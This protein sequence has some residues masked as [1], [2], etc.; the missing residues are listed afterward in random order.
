MVS[1]RRDIKYLTLK[2]R[3]KTVKEKL[4]SVEDRRLAIYQK[5]LQ[6]LNEVEA[7]LNKKGAYDLLKVDYVMLL[8]IER[9]IEGMR[10]TWK[11]EEDQ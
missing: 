10:N 6:A 11:A 1:L 9:R 7:D 2:E 8:N 5:A 4:E 3:G